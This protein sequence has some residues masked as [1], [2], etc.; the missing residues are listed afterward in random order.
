M[1]EQSGEPFRLLVES[2]EGELQVRNETGTTVQSTLAGQK[3]AGWLA[4]GTLAIA[5]LHGIFE[6]VLNRVSA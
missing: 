5:I 6:D 3:V 1:V 4:A 2:G